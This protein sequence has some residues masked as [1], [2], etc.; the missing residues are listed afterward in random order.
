MP[1]WNVGGDRA[2]G[3]LEKKRRPSQTLR[4]TQCAVKKRLYNRKPVVFVRPP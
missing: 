2:R 1:W 4:V 3:H